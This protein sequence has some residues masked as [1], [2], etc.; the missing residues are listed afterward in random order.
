MVNL[1]GSKTFRFICDLQ[2]DNCGDK[3]VRSW[4]TMK[5]EHPLFRHFSKKYS[6]HIFLLSISRNLLHFIFQ[7]AFYC[8]IHGQARRHFWKILKSL[9]SMGR[10][11]SPHGSH[12][13]DLKSRAR[14]CRCVQ[15]HGELLDQLG[16]NSFPTGGEFSSFCWKGWFILSL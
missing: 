10:M 11:G 4:S 8:D 2:R 6:R 12:F 1:A 9:R 14:T 16:V 13:V 3:P 5:G 7:K 15:K